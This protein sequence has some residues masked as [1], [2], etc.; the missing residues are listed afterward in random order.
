MVANV[1]SWFAETFSKE[2]KPKA[3]KQ[4][5]APKPAR[6]KRAPAEPEAEV[7]EET[8]TQALVFNAMPP[9]LSAP[10]EVSGA[11]PA[12]APTIGPLDPA[13]TIVQ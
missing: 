12:L 3:A 2:P 13:S 4:T 10:S 1:K 7:T 5:V 11:T 9:I 8:P 6:M